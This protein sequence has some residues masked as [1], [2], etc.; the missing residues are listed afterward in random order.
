MKVKIS[1]SDALKAKKKLFRLDKKLKR[2]TIMEDNKLVNIKDFGFDEEAGDMLQT[3]FDRQAELQ[4]KYHEI[5]I[6]TLS[7]VE[8]GKVPVEIN[9]YLGQDQIKQ[10]FFWMIIEICEAIDCLKN[11]PWKRTM[12]ETDVDHFREEVADA[13]HFFI[14]GC[15]LAGITASDLFSLY[16]RKSEVNKFRQRSKY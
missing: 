2:D 9:S 16:M 10:R 6:E 3:I 15:I 12:V 11:K 5:Q 14:E 7:H 1:L 13:L 8:P 4:K